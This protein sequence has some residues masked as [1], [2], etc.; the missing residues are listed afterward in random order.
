VN[1]EEHLNADVILTELISANLKR[2]LIMEGI[3]KN[4]DVE[5]FKECK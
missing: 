5:R 1:Q 2:K 3:A 4:M